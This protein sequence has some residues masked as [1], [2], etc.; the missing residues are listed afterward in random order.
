MKYFANCSVYT[1]KVVIPIFPLIY[2]FLQ[3]DPL[4]VVSLTVSTARIFIVCPAIRLSQLLPLF[5]S[6]ALKI[7]NLVL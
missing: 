2:I 6:I 7:N 1:T 3:I 4:L 5:I